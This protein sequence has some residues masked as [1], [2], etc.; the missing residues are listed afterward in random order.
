MLC[1]IVVVIVHL[2]IRTVQQQYNKIFP[3]MLPLENTYSLPY[4]SVAMKSLDSYMYKLLKR[5][6]QYLKPVTPLSAICLIC[7][8]PLL[9]DTRLKDLTLSHNIITQW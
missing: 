4:S 1:D 5:E 7:K 3:R 6:V 8:I 9:F 2:G